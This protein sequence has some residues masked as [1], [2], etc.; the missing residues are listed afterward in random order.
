MTSTVKRVLLLLLYYLSPVVA[1]I[2]YWFEEPVPLSPDSFSMDLI[3]NIASVFGVFSY[4]WMCFN[5]IIMIKI[6]PIEKNV[7]M[8]AL[9]KFHTWMAVIALALAFAH[10]PLMLLRGMFE[11]TQIITGILGLSI[12]FI[13]MAL[14]IIFMTNRILKFKNLR[15]FAYEKKFGYGSNK[16]LHN[17]T[18]FAVF[19]IFIHTIISYTG[20]SSVL[21]S[22]LYFFFFDITLI[23]WLAHKFIRKHRLET[24]PYVNRKA[25]W[26]ILSSEI[27]QGGLKEWS[28]ELIKENPSLY[29]CIQCGSCTVHCPVSEISDGEYNPRRVILSLLLGL[30]D[31]VLE[32]PTVWQCTQCYSCSEN[33][34]QHVELPE[35]FVFLRNK[36]AERNEAPVEFLGEAEV[37]Y[38]YGTAVPMQ[39]AIIRRREMLKLPPSPPEISTIHLQDIQDMLDMV[40]LNKIVKKNKD[41]EQ[42]ENHA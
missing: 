19:F 27:I 23:G 13:L 15:A 20:A 18:M 41:Q 38:N 3:H 2:I 6:K 10:S 30:K 5:I 39:T 32:E 22:G 29:T 28:L 12:F 16:I 26:D 8:K 34:P 40:G 4:I 1:S 24:D 37:V 17:I 11:D 33:C 31:K 14:A 9:L 25:S 42:E 7:N 21:M 35:I 36:L